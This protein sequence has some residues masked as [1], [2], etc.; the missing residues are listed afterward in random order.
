M[1]FDIQ[2]ETKHRNMLITDS[3]RKGTLQL[4]VQFMCQLNQKEYKETHK[5]MFLREF[6]DSIFLLTGTERALVFH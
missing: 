3:E 6:P 5:Y 4:V 1:A 2:V